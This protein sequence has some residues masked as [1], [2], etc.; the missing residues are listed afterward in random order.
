MS[1]QCGGSA[2]SSS[3]AARADD[4]HDVVVGL[5]GHASIPQDRLA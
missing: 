3:K 5:R 1:H 2:E 4:K